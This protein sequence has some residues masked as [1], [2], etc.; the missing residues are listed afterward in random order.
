MMITTR[1]SRKKD[2]KKCECGDYYLEALE[3]ARE[4][5]VERA[6]EIMRLEDEVERL[7][8]QLQLAWSVSENL[9]ETQRQILENAQEN[10]LVYRTKN[11]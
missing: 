8:E 11:L 5:L 1:S 4:G 9:V 10:I 6:R 2:T 7:R 3:K